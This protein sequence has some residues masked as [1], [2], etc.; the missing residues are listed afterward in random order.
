MGSSRCHHHLYHA[1]E[2][3]KTIGYVPGEIAFPDLTTGNA[4]LKSQAEFLGLKDM[5]YANSL[6]KAL[7]LDP[8]AGLKRMSKGMKTTLTGDLS[9][10]LLAS[11]PP[12]VASAIEDVGQMDLYSLIVGSVFF[13]IAGLLLPIIYAIMP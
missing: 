2:I 8:R 12:E 3:A 4:F 5:S 6:V 11:L 13:K 1:S 9:Q 10:S 7:Q